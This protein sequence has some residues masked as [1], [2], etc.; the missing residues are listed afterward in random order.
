MVPR[1]VLVVQ[2]TLDTVCRAIALMVYINMQWVVTVPIS[3]TKGTSP[4]G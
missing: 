4:L 2:Q 1:A 3:L